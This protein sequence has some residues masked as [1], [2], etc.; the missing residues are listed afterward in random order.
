MR[1]P[2]ISRVNPACFRPSLNSYLPR[3]AP[4]D[5]SSGAHGGPEGPAVTGP[6][7]WLLR[8]DYCAVVTTRDHPSCASAAYDDS[9]RIAPLQSK[10]RNDAANIRSPRDQLQF[11]AQPACANCSRHL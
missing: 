11:N 10:P 1:A 7:A 9:W 6:C 8:V 3:K 4:G 5:G 2:V